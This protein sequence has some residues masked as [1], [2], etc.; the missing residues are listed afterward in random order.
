MKILSLPAYFTPES[1]AG[2]HLGADLNKAFIKE[3]FEI[4]LYVPSP[5]RGLTREERIR[6]RKKHR[7]KLYDGRMTVNRF[8]MFREGTN[9][10]L[11]TLRYALC[12]LLQFFK[13]WAASGTD[14]VFVASTPPIQGTVAALL[15]KVK[16]IPFVY[17]L[18][19][20]FPDSLVNTGLTKKGSLL[21]KA[22]RILENFTYRNADKIIVIS[23]DFKNNLLQKGVPDEKIK[24]IYN[25]VDEK[26]IVNISRDNNI[27]IKRYNLSK[28]K[29]YITHCGNIGLT[30]NMDMLLDAA[31]ELEHFEDIMF[32]LI[33]DGSYKEQVK[34]KIESYNIKN[35]ILLPFQ[36]YEDI[37]HVFSLGDA[38]LVI[39][40]P[41][42]GENSVPSKTW[43]IMS[44]G[45]PVL[46]SFDENELKNIIESNACGIFTRSG[47]KKAFKEAIITLYNDRRKCLELGRNA[48]NFI[49]NNLTVKKGTTE[50]VE[51][52][53]QCENK[54]S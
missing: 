25:W 5:S 42:I 14:I 51:V 10:F 22:G 16:K 37:S 17:W 12:S 38:S 21:W 41:G 52:I 23:K 48:R 39:S 19:D 7:E 46:A 49:L 32:V 54:K 20:I 43:S 45:C 13:G 53:K 34:A 3:G 35:V 28:D 1:V 36:P 4:I 31:T 29:F 44:A 40:K 15:K 26:M 27:L 18:Q 2:S 11:R 47:D 8:P 24:I 50:Y 9:P 33:G 30:Q 6:Y